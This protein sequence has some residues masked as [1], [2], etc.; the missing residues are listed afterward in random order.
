MSQIRLYL[1]NHPWI[2]ASAM[3]AL[4]TA[5]CWLRMSGPERDAIWE[6]DGAVFIGDWLNRP[7]PWLI[8]T[9]YAGYVNLIPRLT[10]LI[11]QLMPVADWAILTT[12]ASCA[13]VGL[14]GGIAFYCC[15]WTL[16]TWPVRLAVGL[17]PTLLPLAGVQPLGTVCNLHWWAIYAV[18][19]I[20]VAQPNNRFATIVLAV[21]AFV[22]TMSE[23]MVVFLVPLMIWLV[24]RPKVAR[25]RVVSIVVAVGCAWQVITFLIVGRDTGANVV[26]PLSAAIKGWLVNV[27]GGSIT[28]SLELVRA[29]LDAAGYQALGV[30]AMFFIVPILLALWRAPSLGRRLMIAYNLA[31]SVVLWF[32]ILYKNGYPGGLYATGVVDVMLRWGVGASLCLSTALLLAIDQLVTMRTLRLRFAVLILVLLFAVQCL[33]FITVNNDRSAGLSWR[34]NVEIAQAQCQE[35]ASQIVMFQHPPWW[36]QPG[37]EQFVVPCDRL[38]R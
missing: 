11:V 26:T 22:F 8:V 34:L 18:F 15:R 2:A 35:G 10:Q 28:S 4:A 33:S 23:I 38:L 9:P 7:S 31:L 5:I 6:E 20:I 24:L 37:W 25:Q 30:A 29:V 17:V 32:F 36:V 16:T 13:V 14:V 27:I 1:R 12:A 19:W 3:W 21:V